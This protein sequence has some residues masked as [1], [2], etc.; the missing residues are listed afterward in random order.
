MA[1]HWPLALVLLLGLPIYWVIIE[2]APVQRTIGDESSYAIVAHE[3]SDELPWTLLPGGMLLH[4]RPPLTFSFFSLFADPELLEHPNAKRKILNSDGGAGFP[5]MERF[6]RRVSAAHVALLAWISIVAYM[7]CRDAGSG[8]WAAAGAAGLIFLNPRTG[9][10]VQSAWSEI[11]HMALYMTGFWLVLRA[12]ER[13][14]WPDWARAALFVAAGVVFAYA[15]FTRS[16]VGTFVWVAVGLAVFFLFRQ[17]G[18]RPLLRRGVRAV[19]AGALVIGAFQLTLWPQSLANLERHGTPVV[20]HNTWLNIEGGLGW[21]E[22][23]RDVYHAAAEDPA[24]KE[25]LARRRVIHQLRTEPLAPLIVRQV[26]RFFA[27]ISD[28]FLTK[29]FGVQRWGDR[30]KGKAVRAV[31]AV[32]SWC[33]FLGGIAGLLALPLWGRATPTTWLLSLF[34][35]YYGAGLLVVIPIFRMYVQWI[36]PLAVL[37]ALFVDAAVREGRIRARGGGSAEADGV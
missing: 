27:R 18:D 33:L 14:R 32:F 13:E 35:L 3:L 11:L 6:M 25:A 36:P 29:A 21:N 8:R 1:D 24:E 10:Y 20:A 34:V 7:L 19:A 31:A 9:F 23:F 30:G 15:R 16:V 28:S 2:T 4:R 12:T 17:S 37:A 22:D 5:A 26:E